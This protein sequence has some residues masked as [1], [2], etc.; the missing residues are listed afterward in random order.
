MIDD[1][2]EDAYIKQMVARWLRETTFT[3]TELQTMGVDPSMPNLMHFTG[4]NG[5][6][7][8][9]AWQFDDTGVPYDLLIRM[10]DILQYEDDSLAV[11]DWWMSGPDGR[12]SKIRRDSFL[13]E[14]RHHPA[15]GLQH[16]R[17]Y[18]G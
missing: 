18:A 7:L 4:P 10:N 1:T 2:P 17:E 8:F 16:A 12:G 9:F 15:V 6:E 13:Q 11:I 3:S 5:D 14:W